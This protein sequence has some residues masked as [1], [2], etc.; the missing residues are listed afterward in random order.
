M[1][2][3]VLSNFD[4]VAKFTVKNLNKDFI[5][6]VRGGG[7]TVL[8]KY[9]IK[10]RYFLK[11]GFPKIQSSIWVGC[12]G[13]HAGIVQWSNTWANNDHSFQWG[14]H[15]YNARV[16]ICPIFGDLMEPYFEEEDSSADVIK[17]DGRSCIGVCVCVLKQLH[18]CDCKRN[19]R[20][21]IVWSV[22]PDSTLDK[23][24]LTLLH[25][26]IIKSEILYQPVVP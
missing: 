6:A 12:N 25:L 9:F 15:V 7:V 22:S 16:I 19:V 1:I 24:G 10:F 11:D 13:D 8:W 18:V 2:Y 5:N 17:W 4:F 20:G 3:A 14:C 21:G 23:T 26:G